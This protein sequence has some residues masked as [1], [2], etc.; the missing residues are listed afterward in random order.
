MPDAFFEEMRQTLERAYLAADEPWR[1]SGFSG[2]EARWAVLRKP[3]ADCV[4]RSGSFLDVGCANGYLLESVRRWSAFALELWG[5]D[6]SPALVE[7]A[8]R[9]VPDATLLVANALEWV[10]PRRFDFVRTELVYVRAA[11]EAR[12]V[13]HL[14]Q[15]CV[16]TDGALLVANYLEG[17]SDVADRIIR[18]AHPTT[19]LAA[20]LGELG[21]P[22]ERLCDAVDAVKGRRTRVAVIRNSSVL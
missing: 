5:I 17:A 10:P 6:L 22:V 11:D 12:Y 7:L 13:R 1:Q 8:R 20:R 9:R 3:V 19:D 2:P 16:S 15:H 14:L 21:F 4:D 18:G